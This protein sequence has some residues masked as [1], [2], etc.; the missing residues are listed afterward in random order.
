MYPR[1]RPQYSPVLA[2]SPHRHDAHP[3]EARTRIRKP[4][5]LLRSGFGLARRACLQR[6]RHCL[7]GSWQP[8]A[9]HRTS[10]QGDRIHYRRVPDP[11]LPVDRPAHAHRA[12]HGVVGPICV[13]DS[14]VRRAA[15]GQLGRVNLQR[16]QD[17]G[18]R[19]ALDSRRPQRDRLFDLCVIDRPRAVS[20]LLR[21]SHRPDH[22]LDRFDK[23]LALCRYFDDD[24]LSAG[25]PPRLVFYRHPN[26]IGSAGGLY[27]LPLD[28]F[29]EPALNS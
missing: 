2:V 21:L 7:C 28:P 29:V 25:A 24:G 20:G 23:I 12:A 17:T 27:K 13:T 6:V 19:F 26:L 5:H 9:P 8:A 10:A 22:L 1:F 15:D 4:P 11:I 18:M 14:R 3:L 16:P